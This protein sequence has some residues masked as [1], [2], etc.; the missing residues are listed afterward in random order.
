[1]NYVILLDIIKSAFCKNKMKLLSMKVF[2]KSSPEQLFESRVIYS[3]YNTYLT[4]ANS[5]FA[6]SP[7]SPGPF[8]AI[9][10]SDFSIRN[11]SEGKEEKDKTC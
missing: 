1:M 11:S 3:Y 10:G 4:Y 7:V 8:I 9:L 6:Q 2:D 5:F